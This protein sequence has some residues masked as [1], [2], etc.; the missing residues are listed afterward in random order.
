MRLLTTGAHR[1]L[2][3]CRRDCDPSSFT[4]PVDMREKP[5]EVD[6]LVEYLVYGSYCRDDRPDAEFFSKRWHAL[7][8]LVEEAGMENTEQ[9]ISEWEA[10][11]IDRRKKKLESLKADGERRAAQPEAEGEE[12]REGEEEEGRVRV[13]SSGGAGS[14]AARATAAA[15]DKRQRV[16]DGRVEE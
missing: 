15:R 7:D 1:V 2:V 14:L 10:A 6:E 12:G 11:V 3:R 16:R 8:D 13:G 4:D 9:K 5:T